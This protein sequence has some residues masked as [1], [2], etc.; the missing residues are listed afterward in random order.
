MTAGAQGRQIAAARARRAIARRRD[1]VR[2]IRRA[3]ATGSIVV[4]LALFATIYVQMAAGRDPVLS[5][6]TTTRADSSGTASS[7]STASSSQ[8]FASDDGFGDEGGGSSGT[9]VAPAP[10]TST[11]TPL[12]PV[13]TSQS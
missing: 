8:G 4:F 5:A 6:K 9:A 3:V 11:A 13:T 7:S 2:S 10:G 1:R 12:P